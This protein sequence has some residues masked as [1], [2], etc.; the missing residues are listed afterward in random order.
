M[1]ATTTAF[2]SLLNKL[3]ND[4]PNLRFATGDEFRWSPATK[5]VWYIADSD[6]SQTLLHE[7]A[8]GLLGHAG[9]T[10]DLELLHLE[11]EAWSQAVEMGKKYGVIIKDDVVESAI[12]TY[13]DWLHTRSLC[14]SCHQNGVQETE[15]QYR[16]VVCGQQWHVNDARHCGLRRHKLD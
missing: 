1:A 10:Q 6:D 16:C 3:T 5:T 8:H 13:R 15:E 2:T 14:P 9:Y 12:D 7:T 11:R 4:L